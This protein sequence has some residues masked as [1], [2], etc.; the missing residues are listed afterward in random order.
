MGCSEATD[1]AKALMLTYD[2]PT[3]GFEDDIDDCA[4]TEHGINVPL[5][6]KVLEHI[7]AHPEEHDQGVWVRRT[8]CETTGCIA[9]H[10]AVIAGYSIYLDGYD[11][12][13]VSTGE[14][15][16]DAA[17]RV[18]GLTS[19]QAFRL[20]F[21]NNTLRDLWRFAERFTRGEIKAPAP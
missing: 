3:S 13:R 16:N 11:M 21:G 15:I 20:F 7:T 14:L 8:L 17:Q 9:Y 2:D 12:C 19:G 10:T 5:L 1:F 6:R 18:L 4:T